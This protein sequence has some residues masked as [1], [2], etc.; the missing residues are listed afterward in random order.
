VTAGITRVGDEMVRTALYEAA[1][2]LLSPKTRFSALKRWG[3]EVAQRPGLK[4]AKVAVAR[5]LAVIL[6]LRYLSS[7]SRLHDAIARHER[8]QR[9]SSTAVNLPCPSRVSVPSCSRPY[10]TKPSAALNRGRS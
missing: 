1:N 6:T 9:H 4:R 7:R 3:L 8:V 10:K 5:K 2:S